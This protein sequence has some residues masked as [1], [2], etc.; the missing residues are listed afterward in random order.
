MNYIRTV[1]ITVFLLVIVSQALK[2]FLEVP[3]NYDDLV[4]SI[5]FCLIGVAYINGARIWDKWWEK[6]TYLVCGIYLI[7]MNFW[8]NGWAVHLFGMLA[9]FTPI[10]IARFHP[11]VKECKKQLKRN[12]AQKP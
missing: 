10:L 6:A 3:Q 5:M 7:A 9:L 12:M 11:E 1:I 4:Y 8:L 2:L